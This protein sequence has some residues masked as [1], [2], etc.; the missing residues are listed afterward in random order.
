MIVLDAVIYN[1]DRHFGNFGVL[2]DSKTNEILAP[3]P[4]FDH[5]NSLFNLAGKDNWANEKSLK[6]YAGTLL[7]C[8]YEDYIEEAK[9]V[10]DSR[11]KEK[12]RKM[13]TYNLQKVGAY[14]YS[15]DR[16]KLISKM[17][18]ERVHEILN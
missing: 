16:L 9:K 14:N 11:L 12:L 10:I 15:S 7:P 13:L 8:V 2:V 4:L 18:Q 6:E 1:T 5:G 3:A 17:V